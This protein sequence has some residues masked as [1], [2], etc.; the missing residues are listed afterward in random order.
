MVDSPKELG[1]LFKLHREARKITQE[2]LA[3]A[4]GT[5][6]TAIAHL[7]QGLRTPPALVEL[8]G[9]HLDV[10]RALWEAFCVADDAPIRVRCH[11]VTYYTRWRDA[12]P[13]Q[14]HRDKL[15]YAVKNNQRWVKSNGTEEEPYAACGRRLNRSFPTLLANRVVVPVP[16]C[17][18]TADVS[19]DEWASLRLAIA[20]AQAGAVMRV[21]KAVIR[22]QTIEKSSDPKRTTPRPTVREHVQSLAVAEGAASLPSRILLVDDVVTRGTTMIACA[23]ALRDAGWRGEITAVAVAYDVHRDD[24]DPG[25]ARV[26]TFV[27]DGAAPYPARDGAP[28][29]S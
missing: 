2:A 14:R 3:D 5:N 12:T 8:V 28:A 27:W 13:E 24:V 21:E 22:E 18:R 16:R 11:C 17:L 15:V 4:L 9:A 19:D 10:P 26:L 29:T 1:L 6:R 25:E 23:V 7:E 20:L